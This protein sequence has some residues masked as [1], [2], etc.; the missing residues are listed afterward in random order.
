MRLSMAWVRAALLALAAL[1]L[2]PAQAVTTDWASWMAERRQAAWQDLPA[3]IAALEQRAAQARQRGDDGDW[4]LAQGR[5]L[6]LLADTS[7]VASEKLAQEVASALATRPALAVPGAARLSLQLGL[8]RYRLAN[9]DVIGMLAALD[10]A[11]QVADAIGQPAMKAEVDAARALQQAYEG[12]AAGAQALAQRALDSPGSG[13]LAHELE[14]GPLLIARILG[15]HEAEQAQ[16]LLAELADRAA[17]PEA[18]GMPYLALQYGATQ[19]VVLRRVRKPAEAQ[20]LLDTW[21]AYAEQRRLQ[22]YPSTRMVQGGLHRDLKDW[23]GCTRVLAGLNS[24]SYTQFIRIE[25]L[26]GTA[27]CRAQAGQKEAALADLA[28]LERSLPLVKDSPA[29]A[30]AV[31]GTQARA[32]EALGDFQNAYA[33]QKATRQATVARF[34]KA[35]EATRQKLETVYQVAAKD[36]ENALLKAREEGLEQRRLWLGVAL[37]AAVLGLLVVAELLRRRSAQRRRLAQL[38]GDL[39]RVN[40]ELVQANAQLQDLNASRTRLV[41]AACHDLRQPAHAL[42]MLAEIASAKAA[43]GP[44]KTLEA[45]RRCS[46]SL[47]DL[48]DMLFDLSRLESDRYTPTIGVVDLGELFGDLRTQFTVTALSKGL[49]LRV[50]D[51]GLPVRTDAHLLR[52]MLMNL[53]SNAIKYTPTGS[54][55]IA[56][57]REGGQVRV[58]VQDTGP[59]IPR[60]QQEAAFAEYVRLDSSRGHDGLGIGLA[61]VKRSAELLG[62]RLELESLPGQGTRFDL[63]LPLH[64]QAAPAVEEPEGPVGAGRV[65]GLV[66]DDEQIRQAMSEFLRLHGFVPVAGAALDDLEQALQ[67]AGWLQPTLVISD[68]H[69]GPGDSLAGLAERMAPGGAWAGVPVILI[70]GD[71]DAHLV[72]RCRALGITI[73]YKP[74]APRKLMQLM[75]TTLSAS[76][77]GGASGTPAGSR[78]ARNAGG[79]GADV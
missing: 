27:I 48:L 1:L 62:H 26:M 8:A 46:A 74:L 58:T 23:A 76:V 40:G 41:A 31:L 47:S 45:I 34:T 37:G 32:Y 55:R 75:E 18:Q 44:D 60:E 59:G 16:G 20:K 50:D 65:V 15:I 78:Q 66:D 70:T 7:D 5:R 4:G 43:G 67:A 72:E 19:A 9:R 39:E 54:V 30:E 28:E 63:W 52:R 38:A 73:A 49:A 56:G 12:D 24:P 36:K 33:K 53:L 21:L 77:G 69:L 25:S 22:V 29:M 6:Q 68:L 13:L 71:L 64:L 79:A 3:E 10:A 42:G 51:V 61:I 14:L 35:N 11:Q 2:L 57:R 17:A